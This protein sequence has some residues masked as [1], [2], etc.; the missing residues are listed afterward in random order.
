[1]KQVYDMTTLKTPMLLGIGIV[2]FILSVVSLICVAGAITGDLDSNFNAALIWAVSCVGFGTLTYMVGDYMEYRRKS[3]REIR[4][5]ESSFRRYQD[6]IEKQ[7]YQNVFEKHSNDIPSVDDILLN[8]IKTT[9]KLLNA[10]EKTQPN[11]SSDCPK[12]GND[13]EPYWIDD[14]VYGEPSGHCCSCGYDDKAW[15]TQMKYHGDSKKTPCTEE[16]F[17]DESVE[18]YPGNDDRE[19][20]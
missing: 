12:C 2:A 14:K 6:A 18:D 19:S 11:N 8:I 7:C 13:L 10:K 16:D 5:L 1:M 4:V 17:E 20:P 9:F 3:E 15:M